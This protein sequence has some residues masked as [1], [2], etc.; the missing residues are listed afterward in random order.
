MLSHFIIFAQT[1]SNKGTIIS[2]ETN[3]IVQHAEISILDNKNVLYQ[4]ISDDKGAFLIPAS[5]IKKSRYIRITAPQYEVLNV[6]I[7]DI[8]S[9]VKSDLNTI[10]LQLLSGMLKEVVIKANRRYRDTIRINLHDEKFERSIMI[11]DLFSGDKGFT[12]DSNGLLYFKGKLVTDVKVNGNDFFGK[13]NLDIYGYLPA[14]VLDNIEIVETNV[15]SL[16]N[17][18]M[19]KPAVKVNLTLKDKYKKGKFGNSNLGLGTLERYVVNGDVYSYKNNA[20]AS[21]SLNS[22]N[23]NISENTLLEPKVAFS[24][25][26]NNIRSNIARFGYRNLYKDKFEINFSVKGRL[27]H[28]NAESELERRDETQ[29]QF[30]STSSVSDLRLKNLE[31]VNL[32]LDYLLDSLSNLLFTQ[33]FSYSNSNQIDS[34]RYYI[35]SKAFLSNSQVDKTRMIAKQNLSTSIL[36]KKRFSGKKGRVLSA[37]I[38]YVDGLNHVKENNNVSSL[39]NQERANYFINGNRSLKENNILANVTFNEPVWND[40][41]IEGFFAYKRNGLHYNAKILSDTLKLFDDDPVNIV[42]NFYQS[43]IKFH[44]VINKIYFDEL[45]SATMLSRNFENGQNDG[46]KLFFYPVVDLK[47]SYRINDRKEISTNFKVEPNYPEAD[48]LTNINNS[49]QLISQM[50]GNANLNPQIKN[51][52]GLSYNS[53]KEDMSSFSLSGTFGYYSS[54]FGYRIVKL[55]DALQTIY[56]DNIGNSINGRLSFSWNKMLKK[57]N[58]FN[59]SAS[60]GYE[61]TPVIEDDKKKFNNNINFSQSISTSRHFFEKYLTVFPVLTVDFN[62]YSYLNTN[63]NTINL[64]YSDKFS[65]LL[66]KLQFNSYPLINCST[67]LSNMFTWALNADIKMDILKKYGSIWVRGYD[68]FNS[69]RYNTNFSDANYIQSIKYENLSRYFIIGVTIK[70][71]NIK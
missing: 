27:Q 14:L 45:I 58:S 11:G 38:T 53:R 68:I 70:F 57:S 29:E 62:R 30:S 1:P 35:T 25:E 46:N 43:G 9:N 32:K 61:E 5:F 63:Y 18:T 24:S 12:K 16:T 19:N 69:F 67:G 20:Q 36:Y 44:K 49:F 21:L 22:N 52:L 51:E 8:I 56:L 48:Q 34:M 7:G 6:R 3:A 42:Y 23:I 59:Y 65:L 10:K 54:R 28:K 4:T 37:G 50:I 33:D 60:I 13:N 40:G 71:N 2:A 39:D 17:A 15:D 31:G 66:G 26:G 47:V 64:S 55:S 41:T